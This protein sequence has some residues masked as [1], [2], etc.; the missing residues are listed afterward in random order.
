MPICSLTFILSYIFTYFYFTFLLGRQ[1]LCKYHDWLIRAPSMDIAASYKKPV[2]W[3]QPAKD[4][5]NHEG[6]FIP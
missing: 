6:E 4:K 5:P 3:L 2:T 1:G